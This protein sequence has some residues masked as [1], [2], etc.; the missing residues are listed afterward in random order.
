MSSQT[1]TE[2]KECGGCR[3]IACKGCVF[4]ENYI[5]GA[6]YGLYR[7]DAIAEI[8]MQAKDK[9]QGV[10]EERARIRAAVAKIVTSPAYGTLWIKRDDVLKIFEDDAE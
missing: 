8:Y 10:A 9:V 5:S 4:H 3:Y 1:G 6:E 2:G 7:H